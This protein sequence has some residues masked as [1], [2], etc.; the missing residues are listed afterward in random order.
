LTEADSRSYGPRLYFL[1]LLVQFIWALNNSVSKFALKGFP[2]LLLAGIRMALAASFII[3]FYWHQRPHD[4][5]GRDFWKLLAFGAVG[6]GMNQFCFLVGVSKTS[7]T[8][9]SLII[10]LTPLLTLLIAAALGQEKITARKVVGLALAFSGILVLQ[11]SKQPDQSATLLGDF[12]IFLGILTFAIYIVLGR[13]ATSSH[14]GVVVNTFGFV[15]SAV[16]LL[17][18]TIWQSR[19]FDFESVPWFSWV[20]LFYMAMFSSVVG[21]LLYYYVLTHMEASRISAFS[22]AQ[23]VMGTT[24]AALLLGEPL[25]FALLISGGLV[26]AGVYVTERSRWN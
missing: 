3:P 25:T 24:L 21:Y 7:V 23:P 18:F 12:I 22:Y 13:R 14:S 19:G 10:P 9:A 6:I 11:L 1:A 2:A 20:S 26:L 17:P 4:W 8:H 5:G 15:G 16:L